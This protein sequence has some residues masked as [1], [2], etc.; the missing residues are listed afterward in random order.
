MLDPMTETS[1]EMAEE[2]TRRLR[3]QIEHDQLVA[4]MS[5]GQP[6]AAA[7]LRAQVGD[8][9]IA[10]GQKMKARRAPGPAMLVMRRS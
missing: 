3:E 8:W 7:R 5:A 4:A 9:L 1:V 2:R 6:G 10:T